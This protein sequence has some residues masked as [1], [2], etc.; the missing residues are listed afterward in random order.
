MTLAAVLFDMDGLLVDTEPIWQRAEDRVVAELGG[1]EWTEEDQRAVLGAS[2]PLAG[3]YMRQRTGSSRSAEEVAAMII[4]G[5]HAEAALVDDP[6]I[7]QPG[8]AE[9]LRDVAGDGV[10]FA[11]VSASVRSVMDLVTAHLGS[12]G[13][14]EFPVTVA[15]DEVTRGKPDPT[16]YLRAAEL[17]GADIQRS[18]VL[19]DSINGVQAGWSSGAAA[20]VAIEGMVCHEPRPRV[21]VRKSLVGL[22]VAALRAF[23]TP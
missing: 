2:L 20:V 9:L 12:L 8:A 22:D 23:V 13:L 10:P 21:V 5:F 15:G 7:I 18:V 11:L 4:A 14:P 19:E 16:P 6:I 17:L 1:T 3:A